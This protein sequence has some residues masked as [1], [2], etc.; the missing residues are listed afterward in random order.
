ML[1]VGAAAQIAG[2]GEA[3]TVPLLLPGDLKKALS[4]LRAEPGRGW[5]IDT[6]AALCGIGRRTLHKHFQRFV[7]RPPLA[8]LRKLRLEEARRQLLRAAPGANVAGIASDCGFTHLGRFATWY[9]GHYGES[10]SAT[11]RRHRHKI[12]DEPPRLQRSPTPCERPGLAVLPFDLIGPEAERAAGLSDEIGAALWRIPWVALALPT[13]ARYQLRGKVRADAQ[14]RLRATLMLLEAA[15]GRYLWADSS[16]GTLADVFAFE[17]RAAERAAQALQPVLRDAEVAR[18]WRQGPAELS[19]WELTMRALP[20]VLSIEPRAASMAL[21]WLERAMELAPHD[22]LPVSLAA[23][24]HAL[25]AGHNYVPQTEAE[26]QTALR[27]AERARLLGTGDPS[28][29]AM[30]AAAYSLSGDLDK[31]SI[32]VDRALALDGGSAWAWGRSG[33]IHTYRGETAGAIEHLQIARALAPTDPLTFVWSFGIGT[34]HFE[35]ACYD[36]AARWFRRGLAEQPKAI[37]V[38]RLLAPV[39][40][41]AGAK[42]EARR[43]LADLTRAFPDLT[44]AQVIDHM[45]LPRTLLDRWAEGLES[46]GMGLC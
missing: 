7:G 24:C 30:L 9:R 20:S 14:G 45:P 37:T 4:L 21:E 11:L 43:S 25:R 29:E 2:M 33:W 1:S 36:E 12:A 16:E 42:D 35:A 27:L 40:A 15:T 13:R 34:A 38:H 32:H 18:A 26:G 39:C 28:A 44:I 10:A 31:A 23:W 19:S 17:Q 46:A 6:L 3:A 8:Y 22:A 41:L 5:T